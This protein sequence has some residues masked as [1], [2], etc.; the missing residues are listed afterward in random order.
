MRVPRSNRGSQTYESLPT[1]LALDRWDEVGLSLGEENSG[2][3]GAPPWT[4][5]DLHL[6]C[7]SLRYQAVT[8]TKVPY[9]LCYIEE[10]PWPH[11]GMA[12][13]GQVTNISFVSFVNIIILLFI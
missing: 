7:Q 9:S 5:G 13:S 4:E 6:Y 1:A 2:S 3:P 10:K 11:T 8:M 12:D